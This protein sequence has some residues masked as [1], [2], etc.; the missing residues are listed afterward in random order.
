MEIIEARYGDLEKMQEPG[1]FSAKLEYALRIGDIELLNRI[2]SRIPK[3]LA[4]SIVAKSLFGDQEATKDL[5]T[6]FSEEEDLLPADQLLIHRL[7]KRLSLID[8][9]ATSDPARL[10]QALQMERP[11]CVALVRIA[12]EAHARKAA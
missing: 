3:L 9:K 5:L 7:K 2:R 8:A 1:S 4:V 10:G 6:F 12:N 11:A